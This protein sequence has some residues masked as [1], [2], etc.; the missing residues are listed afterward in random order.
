MSRIRFGSGAES[1][2][3]GDLLS[4]GTYKNRT[5]LYHTDGRDGSVRSN[6]TIE[7]T[8]YRNREDP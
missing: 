5:I 6:L 3:C 4:S 2:M 8:R 7:K 1:E